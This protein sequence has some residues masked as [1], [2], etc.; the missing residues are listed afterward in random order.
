M[1]QFPIPP[2]GGEAL[3]NSLDEALRDFLRDTDIMPGSQ[4]HDEIGAALASFGLDL[5]GWQFRNAAKSHFAR[6]SAD[7]SHVVCPVLTL[8]F[9][10]TVDFEASG[11]LTEFDNWN[12]DW[13]LTGP[14][15]EAL[16][17]AL[18]RYPLTAADRSDQTFV[19]G[20]SWEER[21]YWLLG[22][23]LKPKIAA[24]ESSLLPRANPWLAAE[25]RR[26][27]QVYFG[28]YWGQEPGIRGQFNLLF[29][30]EERMRQASLI[31]AE[32]RNRAC[33]EMR[34]ADASGHCRN[35]KV[36]V[37][38]YYSGMPNLPPLYRED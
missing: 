11:I 24:I 33:E 23:L 7:G 4:V 31:V 21:A 9:R 30:D 12:D 26:A 25:K 36:D 28:G 22:G 8:V 19:F 6:T 32:L 17:R 14:I 35:H 18:V 10:R 5:L 1:G 27:V 29:P 38:L 20:I 16:N 13:S 34:L 15:R 37:A 3:P 2:N